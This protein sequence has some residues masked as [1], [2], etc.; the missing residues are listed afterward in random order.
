MKEDIIL[1]VKNLTKVYGKG[2]SKFLA[3]DD[4]DLE[5]QA[6][7]SIAIVG[8][9]GSGKSTLMHLLALLDRP[10]S[11]SIEIGG[12]VTSKLKPAE[13]DKVRSSKFG[14]VFQQFFMN[15]R[16]SVID[17]VALPLKI[18]GMSRRQR[19]KKAKE[20]L[21]VVG[22]SEKAKNRAQDLSGGQKQRV[23]VARAIIAEPEIIFADEPTGNLD[24]VTGQ[25]IIDL[26]F[27]INR[28]RGITLIVVTH[29]NNLAQACDRQ[30]NIMDGHIT[31]ITTNSEPNKGVKA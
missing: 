9:S 24:S 27:N 23:C 29:D 11:G 10:S 2:S 4:I 12:Q 13:L 6:G 19:H 20:V 14:F 1:K 30:V 31:S 28:E 8:K 7:E 16:D 17:N 3:L 18:S 21:R 15:A 25:K 5:I 22:L 26:L